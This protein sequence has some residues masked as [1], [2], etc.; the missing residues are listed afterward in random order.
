MIRIRGKKNFSTGNEYI[1][2]PDSLQG[3]DIFYSSGYETI[4]ELRAGTYL[5]RVEQKFQVTDKIWMTDARGRGGIFLKLKALDDFSM[6]QSLDLTFMRHGFSL[7]WITL[8]DKG[9]KGQRH[10][11]SGP[12]IEEITGSALELS[13]FR[14]F[15]IPDDYG[16]L[17]SLLI[18]LSL[19]AGFDLIITTGGTGLGPRDITPE[20]ALD[21]IDKRIPGFEQGML[22]YSLT[23]TPHAMISRAAAG[24]LGQSILLTL[25]GSPK[26]VRENLGVVLPALEH[27]LK[28]LQGDKADCAAGV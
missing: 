18:H 13:L 1:V 11:K 24:T 19:T 21:I 8:S 22:N 26:G 16:L 15:I 6:E 28:K 2:G 10:D 3:K 25:P 5:S 9:S 7:A 4:M 23:K 14:G 27:A 17:K 12:L 20:V